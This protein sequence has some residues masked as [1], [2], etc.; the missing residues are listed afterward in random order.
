LRVVYSIHGKKKGKL[1][2]MIM[3]LFFSLFLVRCI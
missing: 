1:L 2:L 3:V